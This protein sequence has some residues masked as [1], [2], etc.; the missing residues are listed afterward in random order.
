MVVLETGEAAATAEK[1]IVMIKKEK[2]TVVF[3][4]ENTLEEDLEI[5]CRTLAS[6]GAKGTNQDRNPKVVSLKADVH[7]VIDIEPF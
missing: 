4:I 7:Q 1:G 2:V 3:E 6:N 5:V